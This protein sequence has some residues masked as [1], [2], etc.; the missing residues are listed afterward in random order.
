MWRRV[1][2]SER[3]VTNAL[4][5]LAVVYTGLAVFNA[6]FAAFTGALWQVILAGVLFLAALALVVLVLREQ[7]RGPGRSSVGE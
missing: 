7:P 4:I 2:R 5:V 6:V 1:Q 3:G